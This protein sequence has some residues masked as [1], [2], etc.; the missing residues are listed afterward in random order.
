MTDSIRAGGQLYVPL[1]Y[2]TGKSMQECAEGTFAVRH[3]GV[4]CRIF[5]RRAEN[6]E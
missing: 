6:E 2:L 5:E 1:S 3:E 4:S